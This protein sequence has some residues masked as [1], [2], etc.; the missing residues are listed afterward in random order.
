MV[1]RRKFRGVLLL[2]PLLA[3]G[4]AALACGGGGSSSPTSPGQTVTVQIMDNSFNPKDV[5]INPGDTVTWVD[6]GSAPLHTVSAGDG[7]FDSGNSLTGKG[8]SFSHTFN[9]GG[10]TVLYY[11]KVHQSCCLMQ[12]AVVVGSGPPPN[13]G[14]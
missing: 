6:M 8:K 14:Y 11:C 2:T 9:T 13:P 5:N 4:L 3:L 12:G 7:S 10:V 1:S